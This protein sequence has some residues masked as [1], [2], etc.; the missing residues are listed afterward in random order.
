M[1]TH[2]RLVGQITVGL[3]LIVMAAACSG[4]GPDLAIDIDNTDGPKE[5]TVTVDSSGPGMTGGEDVISLLGK[6]RSGACRS[7][8]RG[9][10]RSTASTS[11]ARAIGPTSRS[12][13]LANG[14]TC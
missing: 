10:S 6:G 2:R 9:K 3:L 12:R 8:P 13:H 1:P 7:G 5:V 11:S 4:F 14:R